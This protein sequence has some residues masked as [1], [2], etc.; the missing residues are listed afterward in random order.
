MILK[1]FQKLG[2]SL[3]LPIAVLPIAGLLLRL[4][5]PDVLGF[6]GLEP[7]S[8][9]SFIAVVGG[10]IFDNLALIF[11]V[12]IA[13]GFAVDS[14]GAAALAG[15]VSYFVLDN[16]VKAINS[17]TRL[18][19]LAV[20]Y[21]QPMFDGMSISM[22]VLSGIV[23][24]IV[25]GMCYN[26][27]KDT[28]L[29]EWLGFF[30]GKRSVSIMS[31]L[32]SVAITI[33]IG[34]AWPFI[35]LNIEKI[36]NYITGAGAFG[37]FLY[38]FLNRLLIPLGLHHVLNSLVW[39]QFGTFENAE[40]VVIN[41]DLNRFFEHDPTAGT[42]MSGFFPIFMFALPAACLAMYTC[43]KSKNKKTAYGALFSVALTSFVTGITEPIEFMF[44]FL[45]PVLYFIHAVLT[46][47]SMAI[48]YILDVKL[49]FTF[50]AG[51]IDYGLNFTFATNPLLLIP[52]GL[53]FGL[54]YYVLF[55]FFIKKFDL[56]TIGREDDD[57]NQNVS[58][59]KTVSE[60]NKSGSELEEEAIQYLK[61]L[62]GKD[63]IQSMESCITR[64]RLVLKDNKIVDD[65]AVKAVGAQGV[66]RA[67]SEVMQI[68]VGTKAEALVEEM[69]KHLNDEDLLVKEVKQVQKVKEIKEI[70]NI[71]KELLSSMDGEVKSIDKTPDDVFSQKMV[72]DGFVVFPTSGNV[73][74]PVSGTVIQIAHTY[75][76]VTIQTDNDETVLIHV[77]LDTVALK[78]EGF[79]CKVKEG[80]KVNAGDLL[81]SVNLE[82]LKSK[83]CELASPCIY[84]TD[85]E[86]IKINVIEGNT[87]GGKTVAA[88][89]SK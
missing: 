67:G 71:S 17:A 48:M 13:V 80:D 69:N 42:F 60:S 21:N 40:G 1:F 79:D 43:A 37:A 38:G 34:F 12:G 56:K 87:T 44:M 7:T 65:K 55:V 85:D 25:G 22:G 73:F 88:T 36:G 74:A 53:A 61:L 6:F 49:G 78:G 20:A 31:G 5:Q 83:G 26:K 10:S 84:L 8:S 81:M 47:L 39:F 51:F 24:G 76:A 19:D 45:A 11:A 59:T 57:E 32:I 30:S 41:G 52:V 72:G 16:G 64:V 3:M 77:G 27:F 54:L 15:V 68:I 82:F 28:K 18:Q 75:H 29:P 33:P 4:G 23:A 35:Q 46:G 58:A 63:N 14:N 50:S 62:G 9:L 89:L 66:I 70:K 2:K 86:S